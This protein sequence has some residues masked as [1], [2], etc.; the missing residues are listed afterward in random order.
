LRFIFTIEIHMSILTLRLCLT[1]CIVV[2]RNAKQSFSRL[3]VS[4]LPHSDNSSQD[5]CGKETKYWILNGEDRFHWSF[6]H[7]RKLAFAGW[8]AV[9]LWIPSAL[10]FTRC[11]NSFAFSALYYR[12]ALFA[13]PG[14]FCD[15]VVTWLVDACCLVENCQLSPKRKFLIWTFWCACLFGS[16]VSFL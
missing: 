15:M 10:P 11:R 13:F 5:W 2:D 8:A 7:C 4:V 9:F 3:S 6:L 12:G 1:D 14:L 16:T